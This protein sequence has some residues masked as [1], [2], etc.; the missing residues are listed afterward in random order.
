MLPPKIETLHSWWE[1]SERDKECIGWARDMHEERAPCAIG[2]G[3]FVPEEASNN[4]PPTV[5]TSM[6]WSRAKTTETSR[7]SPDSTT[8]S[9]RENM[10]T[11]ESIK[12]SE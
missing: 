7:T 8:M 6:E 12:T 4:K 2:G 11:D 5:R 1:E 10:H 9:N 3:H